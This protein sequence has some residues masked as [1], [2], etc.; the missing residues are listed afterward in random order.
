MIEA[1]IFDLYGVLAINGWQAFKAVHFA[2]REEVWDQVFQLGRQVDAGLSDYA[3]LIHFTVEATG[4][5]EATVRYQLEHTVAN[6]ELVEFIRT[7]LLGRYKLGILSNANNDE[8]IKRIFTPE[9]Q[10]LFDVILLS[11]HVGMSKP[12]VRMYEVVAG[13]LDVPISACLFVDD[14]EHH[15]AGASEAGMQALLYTDMPDFKKDLEIAL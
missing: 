13:R 8:V 6:V 4:E 5:S 15:V 14:R 9:Q 1:I 3:E 2:D 12:D 11:H 7:E 10:G